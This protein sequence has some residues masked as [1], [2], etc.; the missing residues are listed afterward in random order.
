MSLSLVFIIKNMLTE[1]QVQRKNLKILSEKI[2]RNKKTEFWSN[3][4]I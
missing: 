2:C 3:E 4:A 1:T